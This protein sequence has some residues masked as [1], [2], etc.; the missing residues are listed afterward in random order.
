MAPE[1]KKTRVAIL[2][3]GVGALTAALALTDPENPRHAEYELTVYQIGWRLGGKGASGRNAARAERIEEHGLHIWFGC[4]D[5]AF[6]QIRRVYGELGRPPDAPLATW[7]E[8]FKPH[9]AIVINERTA[10]GWGSWLYTIPTNDMLPGEG[11]LVLPPWEYVTLAI[12]F[13]IEAVEGS[14]HAS[15]TGDQHID[16]PGPIGRL[17]NDLTSDLATELVGLGLRLLHA[18]HRA[19]DRSDRASDALAD[20]LG[21]SRHGALRW[22]GDLFDEVSDAVEDGARE[23]GLNAA[24]TLLSWFMRWMWE[25]VRGSVA[26]DAADR[27]LWIMLNFAYANLRG[28]LRDGVIERGFDHLN[29]YDYREWLGRWAFDDGRLMLDSAYMLS[30][31]DAMFAYEDGDNRIPPGEVFPPKAKLE[32]GSAIRCGLRQFLCY[33]GAAVWKMQ[34]GM[35]DTIFGPIYEVLRR[36]GV[37]FQFFH[38]V[39]AITP[40][41]DGR[42]VERVLIGRQATLT[43]EQADRGGYDPMIDIK[44]LPCWPSE[45]RYEQLAEGDELRERRVDLEGYAG[46]WPD[47]AELELRA[48]RDFD[49]AVL[50]ISI[51]ALPYIARDL[52]AASPRWRES[53]EQIKTIRTQGLQ[54]WLDET[55]YELGWTTMERPIG[56]AY[57]VTPLS[58]WADFSHLIAREDWPARAWPQTLSYFCGPMRDEPPL[59]DQGFGPVAPPAGLDQRVQNEAAYATAREFVRGYISPI[60]PNA[61]VMRDK[62]EVDFRWPRLVDAERDAP[63][64]E[65]R[66]RSQFWKANVQPSERYV[67]SVPG[68]SRYRLPAHDPEGFANLYLA[69]DWIDNGLNVGCVEAATMGGLLAASALGGYPRRQDIVGLDL[70]PEDGEG[71]PDD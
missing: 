58:A 12:R 53:V 7:R 19:A 66:L 10:Q 65:R 55:A 49:A 59:Q 20:R 67:L 62:T 17:V 42:S 50:G 60:Y 45:P 48:G 38:R 71:W 41:A 18:A 44:G 39:R 40:A 70:W 43:P 3:G 16:L 61:A 56:G 47:V 33:K 1:S 68:S 23:L 51:G 57:A 31:Y 22:L 26:T 15:P 63:E 14:R 25:R 37:R 8:A 28:A 4:Y 27:H 36:R 54:L 35:G 69:G 9:G 11:N 32:A 2:G 30:I 52:I 5:N 64:D 21:A 13:M 6:R 24:S 29:D 34:A 46:D